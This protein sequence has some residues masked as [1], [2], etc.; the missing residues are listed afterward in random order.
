M[1]DFVTARQK[2]IHG[3]ITPNDVTDRRILDAMRTLPRE[4]FLPPPLTAMAYVDEDVPLGQGRFMTE[5]LVLARLVQLAAPV[6]GEKAL[7]I[8][9]NTGYGA[10]LLAMCGLQVTALESCPQ[11]A[12]QARRAL[13]ASVHLVEGPL[14]DGWLGN[15]PYDLIL[16]EGAVPGIPE[17]LF[18]QLKHK[19][20]IAAVM[21]QDGRRG[22]GVLIQREGDARTLISAFEAATPSLPEFAP[23]AEFAF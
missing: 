9:A 21:A 17:P 14:K 7:V 16:I 13:P 23:E 22:Q 12:A 15:A 5:P 11:L 4:T 8:G 19:G 1:N 3:Q 10:A 6:A 18:V 2:M 20:R